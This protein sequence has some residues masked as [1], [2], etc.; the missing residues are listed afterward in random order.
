V[1][2]SVID[3]VYPGLQLADRVSY[4]Q[5][6]LG[7]MLQVA[8]SASAMA[9]RTPQPDQPPAQMLT[10]LEALLRRYGY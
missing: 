9:D 4:C 5:S 2:I 8:K 6:E 7:Q 3:E 10:G 1:L